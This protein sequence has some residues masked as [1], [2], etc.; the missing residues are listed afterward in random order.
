MIDWS[1]WLPQLMVFSSL[2]AALLIFLLRD[3]QVW[4]RTILNMGGASLKIVFAIVA[5]WGVLAR[6]GCR[7][8]TTRS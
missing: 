2:F 1:F 5:A 3:E 7:F 8:S 6:R 4:A